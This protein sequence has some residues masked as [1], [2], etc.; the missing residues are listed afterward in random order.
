M[1]IGAASSSKATNDGL[2]YSGGVSTRA[3]ALENM[4]LHNQ[5]TKTLRSSSSRA[6]N[7]V[8]TP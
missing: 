5:N 3:W 4:I 2:R 8:G 7:V 6:I 1:I